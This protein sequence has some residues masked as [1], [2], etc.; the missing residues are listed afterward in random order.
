[1]VILRSHLTHFRARLKSLGWVM[2]AL[3]CSFAV[4]QPVLAC[5]LA[6]V[7]AVDV[8][9]SISEVEYDLQ[10]RGIAEALQHRDVVKAIEAVGGIWLHGFEWSG[11]YQQ[12]TLL[13]WQ[14]LSDEASIR[15][16]AGEILDNTRDS[17]EFM[18]ALGHAL[19]HASSV[20]A[21]APQRCERNVV[22]VSA[23][24]INNEGYDPHVAYVS[25]N[26]SDITVNALVIRKEDRT[27]RYFE[28]KVIRGP[29]AFVQ[30]MNSYENYTEAMVRKLVREILGLGFADSRETGRI[31]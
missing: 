23:D 29:G 13:D 2:A 15:S 30:A 1:M 3:L 9:A 17:R 12:N 26:F 20:L 5:S 21:K 31:R 7:V 18:T 4:P 10:Q 6:L 19:S 28:N 27:Y 25:G 11:R 14:F 22:D 8:S 24:G 16:A